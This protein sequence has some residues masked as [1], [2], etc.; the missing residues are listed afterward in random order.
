MTQTTG[1]RL[2]GGAT[3]TIPG[4]DTDKGA[5]RTVDTNAIAPQTAHDATGR[6]A[7]GDA[8]GTGGTTLG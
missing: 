8:I 6:H 7:H 2:H 3:T 1:D 5:A 4:I